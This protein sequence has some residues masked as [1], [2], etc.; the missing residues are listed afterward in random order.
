ME[1][2]PAAERRVVHGTCCC[3]GVLDYDGSG[4]LW[5]GSCSGGLAAP[6][7]TSAHGSGARARRG[8]CQEPLR[9]R[10][11]HRMP[12][13][14]WVEDR[15]GTPLMGEDDDGF[16]WGTDS[17]W[18][19]LPD[20]RD[21]DGPG[22]SRKRPFRVD[23]SLLGQAFVAYVRAPSAERAGTYFRALGVRNVTVAPPP[24]RTPTKVTRAGRRKKPT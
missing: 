20:D 6:S 17:A 4:R 14:R 7:T 19:P 5:V 12:T 23:G 2:A 9:L 16:W 11:F 15:D 1:E 21:A 3:S 24:A 13:N 18:L 8:A 22:R 10:V